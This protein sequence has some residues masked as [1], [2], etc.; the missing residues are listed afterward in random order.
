MK[1]QTVPHEM[2]IL[3]HLNELRKRLL[4]SVIALAIGIIA[5][6]I[7]SKYF[8]DFLAGPIGGTENLQSIEVTENISVFMKIS[9]LGG[10][11]LALPFILFQIYGFISTGLIEK[12][13]RWIF[14]AIPFATLL[15]LGGAAFAFFVMLPTAMPFLI[16]FMGISTIPR[17]DNYFG[18]ITNLMFWVGLSFELPLVIFLLAKLGLVNARMLLMGWRYAIVISAVI[19]AVATPT[20]DPINMGILM[21]PLLVLYLLSIILA[22]FAQKKKP[23]EN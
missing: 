16:D 21:A 6:F 13:K 11:I 8:I 9:M 1:K 7:L 22:M 4:F 15:F 10:F 2:G 5:S 14:T 18:F 17:P 20:P 3:D 12:E 19:A 23:S